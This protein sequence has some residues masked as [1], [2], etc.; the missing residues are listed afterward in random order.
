MTIQPADKLKHKRREK[1]KTQRFTKDKN[2]AFAVYHTRSGTAVRALLRGHAVSKD[3]LCLGD[4]E[5][6]VL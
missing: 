1:K 2:L 3:T 6:Q 4:S 5:A